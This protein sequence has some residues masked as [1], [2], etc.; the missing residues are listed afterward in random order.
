MNWEIMQTEY[1]NIKSI[2]K[3]LETKRDEL[4]N[5]LVDAKI[6]KL[7]ERIKQ[8]EIQTREHQP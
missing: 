3:D 4:G 2:I 5:D 6:L 1:N 8:I 7:K